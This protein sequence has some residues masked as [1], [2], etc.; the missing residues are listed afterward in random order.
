[1]FRISNCSS[2]KPGHGLY[3]YFLFLLLAGHGPYSHLFDN[4]FI[5]QILGETTKWKHED[6]SIDMFDFIRE[7]NKNILKELT[8]DDITFIKEL[9]G[10][11]GQ[12]KFI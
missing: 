6:A 11:N 1:M 10:Q 7:E 3:F 12:V 8:G 4:G 2:I 9:I 5:P